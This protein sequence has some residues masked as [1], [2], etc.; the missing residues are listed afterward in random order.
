MKTSLPSAARA[1]LAVLAAALALALPLE[2]AA[3]ARDRLFA[4]G[5]LAALPA[6]LVLAFSREL[7]VPAESEV[8]PIRDGALTIAI[9]EGE[10]EDRGTLA[11]ARFDQAEREVLMPPSP[12]TAAHPALLV[13]LET[14]VH[15][16]S[17]LTGGSPH[18]LRNRFIEAFAE[19]ASVEAV[20]VDWGG[21]TA[22]AEEILFRPLE[23]DPHAAELGPLT[24]LE[25]AFVL[26]DDVP[27]GLYS[28]AAT[29]GAYGHHLTLQS[30]EEEE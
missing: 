4:T 2:A 27:G 1:P 20:E 3:D 22:A 21:G 18:Y 25:L 28:A 30:V 17:E 15:S 29:G 24:E 9:A 14:T 26:S 23:D 7:E 8:E 6:D 12:T 16:L 13:F 19:P 11:Q 5:T 10:G